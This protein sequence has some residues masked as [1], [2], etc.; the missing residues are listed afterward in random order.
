MIVVLSAIF[1]GKDVPL[2]I[3]TDADRCVL[4]T[5]RPTK[6]RGWEVL[7]PS[8]ENIDPRLES[9][10]VKAAALDLFPDAETVIWVDGNI[11]VIDSVRELDYELAAFCHLERACLYDEAAACRR[12]R[13]APAVDLDRQVAAYERAGHPRHWGLWECGVVVRRQTPEN[14]EL[15]RLWWDH[16]TTFT[17][18][19]QVSF[20]F[21]LRELGLR[22]DRMPSLRLDESHF[23]LEKHAP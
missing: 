14:R 12:L 4:F 6:A 16:I 11:S 5:D 23:R 19:D 10:F 17:S 21:V 15:G 7:P 20:P 3:R 8:G 2:P 13:L 1:G 18:R 22:C 9:K